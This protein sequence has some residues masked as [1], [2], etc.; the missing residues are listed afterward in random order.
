MDGEGPWKQYRV[1][2]RYRQSNAWWYVE[3]VATGESSVLQFDI[4]NEGV[5]WRFET[6]A[7]EPAGGSGG[8]RSGGGVGAKRGA[9]TRI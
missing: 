4:R 9:D 6:P 7:A 1:T 2:A 3:A 5:V 8:E